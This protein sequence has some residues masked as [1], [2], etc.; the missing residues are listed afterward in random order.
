MNMSTPAVGGTVSGGTTL[1]ASSTKP[2]LT[3]SNSSGSIQWQSSTTSATTGY[4]NI[5]GATSGFGKACA[6]KFASHGYDLIITG[7]REERLLELKELL[8]KKY[9]T[10]VLV[11]VYDV[12]N[13]QQVFD[14]VKNIPEEWQRI[15]VLINNAAADPRIE[16]GKTSG[17]DW[18][19][20]FARNLKAY[21][22]TSRASAPHMRQGSAIINFSSITVHTGPTNMSAYVATKAGI[23]GFTRSLARELGR[24]GIRVNT[25]SPGWIM[26]ERQKRQIGRAHV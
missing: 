9:N 15:D 23:Q 26:T 25:I 24:R 2:Q 21:F 13:R 17:T 16:L 20:L 5:T 8:E 22:L 4:T 10:A 11:S 6:E 18:D 12:R 19:R 14:A 3:L 1:C 7:R